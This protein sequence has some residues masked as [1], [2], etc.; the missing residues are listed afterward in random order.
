M[1]LQAII[2]SI[3]SRAAASISLPSLELV[4]L[5]F[6]LIVPPPLVDGRAV[7]PP[8]RPSVSPPGESREASINNSDA[9]WYIIEMRN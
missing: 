9:E 5:L 6:A 3:C 4:P 8:M 1:Y 2:L 7:L